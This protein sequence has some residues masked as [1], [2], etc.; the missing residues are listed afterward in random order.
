MHW[1][2]YRHRR[3]GSNLG[4]LPPLREDQTIF[5]SNIRSS[6]STGA[7]LI[8]LWPPRCILSLKPEDDEV[9]VLSLAGRRKLDRR[10]LAEQALEGSNSREELNVNDE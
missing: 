5:G 4:L 3:R 2:V 7:S 1:K 8:N 10:A 9:A 6:L